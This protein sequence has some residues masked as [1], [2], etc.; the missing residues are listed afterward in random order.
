MLQILARAKRERVVK[1]EVEKANLRPDLYR[2][3]AERMAD[4]VLAF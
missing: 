4:F 1:D 3:P 2:D